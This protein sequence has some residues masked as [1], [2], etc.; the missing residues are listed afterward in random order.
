LHINLRQGE[1]LAHVLEEIMKSGN[2]YSRVSP[3]KSML[4][5]EYEADKKPPNDFPS[6]LVNH[7]VE[8]FS[9][10]GKVLD[11]MCGRG[12]HSQALNNAGLE[13][14]CLDMSPDAGEAFENRDERLRTADMML[15]P[16]PYEDEYFDVVWCKSAIE[17]VNGDHLVSEIRR[18]LKPGGKAVI[19][20]TDWIYNYRFHYMDHT[21]GYGTPW[22]KQ[23]M[24]NILMSYGFEGIISENILY[25]SHTWRKGPVGFLARLGCRLIRMLPYPYIDNFTSLTWKIVRFSNEVQLLGFGIKK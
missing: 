21:H 14:W 22:M 20:T 19:L 8:K 4:E 9:L 7:L 13:V 17:H 25:L 15:D 16:F 2:S 18:V 23:S 3:V 6:K 10:E 11:V 24:R 5:V 12:E 1:K